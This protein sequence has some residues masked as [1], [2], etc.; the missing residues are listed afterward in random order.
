MSYLQFAQSGTSGS[1]LTK[2]WSVLGDGGVNVLGRIK[3]HAPWRKYV[4]EPIQGIFDVHC[5]REIG[6]FCETETGA[7]KDART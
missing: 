2:I 5:L 4:F 7:H 6:Q 3:W 1:G